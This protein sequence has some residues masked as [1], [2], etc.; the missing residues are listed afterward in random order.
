MNG[1]S[2]LRRAA[3][4]GSWA[5][6]VHGGTSFNVTSAGCAFMCLGCGRCEEAE[7]VENVE[8]KQVLIAARACDPFRFFQQGKRLRHSAE[9]SHCAGQIHEAGRK[10]MGVFDRHG[11]RDAGNHALAHRARCGVDA[12]SSS[13][14][15]PMECERNVWEGS[16]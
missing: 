8:S 15:C 14:R 7:A 12:R 3:A 9:L 4:M 11:A 10:A 2:Q 16:W 13:R 1:A 5:G 6:S